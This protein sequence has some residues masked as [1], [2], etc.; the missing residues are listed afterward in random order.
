LRDEE[1]RRKE[2]AQPD[3]QSTSSLLQQLKKNRESDN[4]LTQFHM[5]FRRST[6]SDIQK[7]SKQTGESKAKI[8]RTLVRE[9]LRQ[10]KEFE[11]EDR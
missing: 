6:F 2:D 9:Q 7:L 4:R 10:I 1:M 5:R 8:I 11:G 3:E